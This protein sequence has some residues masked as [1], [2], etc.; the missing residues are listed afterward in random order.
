MRRILFGYHKEGATA[1]DFFWPLNEKSANSF[2]GG[3]VG[4]GGAPN[5]RSFAGCSVSPEGKNF[6]PRAN[7]EL[8]PF[9]EKRLQRAG[10]GGRKNQMLRQSTLSNTHFVWRWNY[11][12][13]CPQ[14]DGGGGGVIDDGTYD[15]DID[16]GPVRTHLS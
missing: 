8:I 16:V 1:I 12:G 7:S 10:R 9:R 15:M 11:S 6:L 2:K 14:Y 13:Q 4:G 5:W 3:G